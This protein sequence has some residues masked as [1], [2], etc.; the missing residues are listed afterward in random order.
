MKRLHRD[1]QKIKDIT[2]NNE[3]A[4]VIEQILKLS[5][6]IMALNKKYAHI[7]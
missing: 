6:K 2:V 5:D 4:T 3:S 1:L 7:S